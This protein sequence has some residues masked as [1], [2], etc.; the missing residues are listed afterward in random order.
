MMGEG[1]QANMLKF[2]HYGRN[3]AGLNLARELGI[4]GITPVRRPNL[5]DAALELRGTRPGDLAIR[6]LPSRPQ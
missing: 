5:A 2:W 6:H 3:P 4:K 1:C